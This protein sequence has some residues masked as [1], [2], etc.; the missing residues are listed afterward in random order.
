MF[1]NLSF[2][3][4]IIFPIAAIIII[5]LGII[6]YFYNRRISKL[7]EES[8]DKNNYYLSLDILKTDTQSSASK[9]KELTRKYNL[10]IR[11]STI[12]LILSVLSAIFLL[13]RPAKIVNSSKGLQSRD[14]VLC[15]DVSGSVLQYDKMLFQSYLSA[16][17][18]F[19]TE[20]I[21]L[22]IFDST[23]R[24]VFP[25]TDDHKLITQKLSEAVNTL[26]PIHENTKS[27]D[28]TS[29]QIA[30]IN[31]FLSGTN[32]KDDKASLVGDGLAT[33]LTQFD[34]NDT[35]NRS[36]VLTTDNDSSGKSIFTLTDSLQYASQLSADVYAIYSAGNNSII[37]ENA[38]S[39]KKAVEQRNGYF[40]DSLNSNSI[41]D[42]VN[43]ILSS[44][45]AKYQDSNEAIITEYTNYILF[46]L[47]PL[48]AL[49]IIMAARMKQ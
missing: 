1:E 37:T 28:L 11:F 29:S 36:V 14:I 46:L 21:S 38:Q 25:L 44:Q 7:Y 9:Y 3:W 13:A 2:I 32:Q 33:C 43:L 26:E 20:R 16:M 6:F 18:S 48:F 8:A 47:V 22:V 45:Q 12:F 19:A 34:N 49:Y 39:M 40:Y 30:N 42:I 31:Q 24:V 4:P 41:K 35:R 15:A 23:A 27:N 17:N 10:F 5:V